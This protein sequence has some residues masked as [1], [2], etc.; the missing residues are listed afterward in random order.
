MVAQACH[1]SFLGGSDQEDH[2][3]R[4]AWRGGSSQDLISTIKLGV[5]VC[6]FDPSYTGGVNRRTEPGIGDSHL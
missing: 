3:L 5:V 4:P 6:V 2:D 1:A